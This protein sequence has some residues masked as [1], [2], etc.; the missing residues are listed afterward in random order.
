MA[1]LRQLEAYLIKYEKTIADSGHG[2]ILPDG[3]KQYGG[4]EIWT[5]VPVEQLSEA[6]GIMFL[7]PLC[8]AKNGGPVG[9]HSVHV[10]FE[11]RNVP[12][13][14]G[15]NNDQGQPSRWNIIGGNGLDDLQL[16]PSIYTKTSPCQWHGYIG[17]AG[18]PAGCANWLWIKCWL[19]LLR[20]NKIAFNI[21][22]VRKK[23]VGT[24]L[25]RHAWNVG[26]WSMEIQ[27]VA[28]SFVQCI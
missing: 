8:F 20:L 2:R 16:S 6:Q 18:V 15:S 12:V 19:I 24:F 9:T 10:S 14:A 5:M 28:W 27:S 21:K 17:T 1:S 3:T 23:T 7:C 25:E 11:G 22:C 26:G 4:F 13:E